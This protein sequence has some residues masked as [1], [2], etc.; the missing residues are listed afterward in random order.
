MRQHPAG[1]CHDGWFDQTPAVF[2]RIPTM[3]PTHSD[4]IAPTVPI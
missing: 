4:L 1:L 2:V 3:P